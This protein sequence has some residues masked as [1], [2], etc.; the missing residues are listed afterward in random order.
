MK[1]D[2]KKLDLSLDTELWAAVGVDWTI[3]L[4]VRW[5]IEKKSKA[6]YGVITP[7]SGLYSQQELT[8]NALFEDHDIQGLTSS[9]IV[10][11]EKIQELLR[12]APGANPRAYY[13]APGS[14]PFMAIGHNGD[15]R[16]RERRTAELT[17]PKPDRD[18]DTDFVKFVSRQYAIP[19]N[20]IRAVL[21]AIG[22]EGPKWMIEFRRPIEL[23]FCTLI[24][25]PFRKNWLA[26]I[27]H[28]F[29][30]YPMLD[31]LKRSNRREVLR[32]MT[33]PESMCS[34]QNLALRIKNHGD[35]YALDYTLEAIPTKR[36]EAFVALT[37][38]QRYSAKTTVADFEKTVESLYELLLK[39]LETYL[40]KINLPFGKVH[41]SSFHGDVRLLPTRGN[42][43]SLPGVGLSK[44]PVYI[45]PPSSGF[46]VQAESRV[47]NV[48]LPKTKIV[49]KMLD[50]RPEDGH[51][52]VSE[53]PRAV[54]RSDNG[55]TQTD[56]VPL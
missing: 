44:L 17:A 2:V 22:T 42:R 20:T 34:P 23:G 13:D 55:E 31:I 29:K 48:V 14:M 5:G 9:W 24:A 18:H 12:K 15:R 11:Q 8:L 38:Q 16:S 54:D 41:Q 30:E 1:P 37:G 51:V 3:P 26:I 32:E 4:W 10:P 28:K 25:A 33:M 56:R 47:E 36:F 46:S 52:R 53:E 35:N 45:I 7:A 21:D 40:H 6:I 19:A 39:A 49:S 27:A 50:S 43:I